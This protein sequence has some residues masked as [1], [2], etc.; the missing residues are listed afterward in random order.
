MA[1]IVNKL[2]DRGAVLVEHSD[3][4]LAAVEEAKR[5][6][7]EFQ[8]VGQR[9][10][11]IVEREVLR[12]AVE[13]VSNANSSDPEQ[14]LPDY[15]VE[16]A[17]NAPSHTE[18]N[19]RK[20]AEHNEYSAVLVEAQQK[21]ELSDR[22][23]LRKDPM[24]FANRIAENNRRL[25]QEHNDANAKYA[26]SLAERN[27]N[28]QQEIREL[29]PRQA[30]E[31]DPVTALGQKAQVTDISESQAS[32]ALVTK[33]RIIYGEEPYRAQAVSSRE[34]APSDERALDE[35]M[36]DE[37]KRIEEPVRNQRKGK[38]GNSPAIDNA[39][40]LGQANADQNEQAPDAI[41]SQGDDDNKE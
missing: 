2:N 26:E 15:L 34:A 13:E 17:D 20:A 16:L 41:K 6:G 24:Y 40:A 18:L 3:E 21:A 31:R 27:E 8:S 29:T 37:P 14:P 38:K 22:E 33:D 4:R 39:S 10:N 25:A 1:K 5:T 35:D 12:A 19:Q 28:V 23:K 36:T 7:Q 32:E 9:G 11:D 30:V